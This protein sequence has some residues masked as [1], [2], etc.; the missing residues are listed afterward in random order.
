MQKYEDSQLVRKLPILS[1]NPF[2]G[3]MRE[4]FKKKKVRI[5]SA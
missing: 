5:T 4:G 1:V 2:R 3:Y